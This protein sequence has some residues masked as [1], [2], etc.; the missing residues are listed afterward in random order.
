M[1]IVFDGDETGEIELRIID[2][3]G[4][5]MLERSVSKN[6]RSIRIPVEVKAWPD[7]IYYYQLIKGK[8]LTTGKFIIQK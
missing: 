3:R 6:G 1:E 2:S 7:G 4:S 5:R 8:V